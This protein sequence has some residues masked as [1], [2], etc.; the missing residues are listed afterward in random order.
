MPQPE[1]EFVTLSSFQ[2]ASAAQPLRIALEDAGIP[3]FVADDNAVTVNWLWGPALGYVK[4]QVP[5]SQAGAALEI[6]KQHVP[7]ARGAEEEK[8]SVCLSCGAEMPEDAEV[9]PKCGW[10]FNTEE[11][12]DQEGNDE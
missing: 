2:T 4:V 10:T 11:E 5:K 3:V 9:C 6:A 12:V 7:A 1:D 8:P